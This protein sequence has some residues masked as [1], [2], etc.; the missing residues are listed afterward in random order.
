MATTTSPCICSPSR[1]VTHSSAVAPPAWQ[2]YSGGLGILCDIFVVRG[3]GVVEYDHV[4]RQGAFHSQRAAQPEVLRRL[5]E[6]GIRASAPFGQN[7][8]PAIGQTDQAVSADAANLLGALRDSLGCGVLVIGADERILS[9]TPGAELILRLPPGKALGAPCSLLPPPLQRIIRQAAASHRATT[10]TVALTTGKTAPALEVT[11]APFQAATDRS[12][13]VVVLNDNGA[14]KRV[15]QTIARLDRLASLGTLSAGMAHEIKNAFVAVKTFVDLLLDK[16][17]DA[18]LGGVVRREMQRIDT[19][20]SQMLKFG[21]PARPAFAAV[22]VHDVLDHSLRMLQ[23][24]FEGKLISLN[25]HFAAAPDAIKGD[26]YQLEQAFVNLL[27][28]ALEAMGPSGSLTV[29]TDVVAAAPAGK[30]S[31][32]NSNR[33]PHVCVTIAD[34][35]IGIAPENMSHLFEPF[36]TTKQHGTGLGLTIARR[37]VRAHHGDITVQS[38]VNK[39]TTFRIILPAQTRAA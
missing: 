4:H 10:N 16:N 8:M 7:F 11:A 21:A 31:R 35:G 18:E 9:C 22:R 25:R 32:A 38:E 20:V 12:Q 13:V 2:T 36:F 29:A 5:V 34:T 19:L 24:Q 26:D 39:G 15:E 30:S 3:I 33:G 1:I 23:H 37:V 28:N 14:V 17:R 6:S 27:L